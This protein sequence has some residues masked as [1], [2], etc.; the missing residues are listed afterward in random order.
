MNRKA[1]Y[2]VKCEV[3]LD[4]WEHEGEHNYNSDI[5]LLLES[6][7]RPSIK[8]YLEGILSSAVRRE[9]MGF[10]LSIHSFEYYGLDDEVERLINHYYEMKALHYDID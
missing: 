3:T 1:I 10:N 2:G 6:V 4:Y 8:T 9:G 7:N 5:K